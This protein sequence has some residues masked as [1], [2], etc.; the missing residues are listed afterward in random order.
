MSRRTPSRTHRLPRR[1][2]IRARAASV[3]VAAGALAAVLPAVASASSY[4]DAILADSPAV[5]YRMNGPLADQSGNG[6]TGNVVGARSSVSGAIVGDADTATT[7]ASNAAWIASY[8]PQNAFT[9]EGWVKVAPSVI[10]SGFGCF[11]SPWYLGESLLNAEVG[12]VTNDYGITLMNGHVGFG[13]GNGDHTFCSPGAINDG[14]YHHIVGTWD[15]SDGKRALYIDGAL[16]ASAGDGG[17]HRSP[18]SSGQIYGGSGYFNQANAP[19]AITFDEV[20]IYDKRLSA[21]QVASHYAAGTR[22]ATCKMTAIRRDD[23]SAGGKDT[24]DVTVSSGAGLASIGNVVVSN[25]SVSVPTIISGMTTPV[26]VTAT[27]AV[28]GTPTRFSFNILDVIGRSTFC[29]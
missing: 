15:S 9:L 14:A 29:A 2:S 24:A 6:R 17:D 10:G 8:S 25:G 18:R 22:P 1:A 21:S 23:P 28:Q 3:A 4:S 16:V 19:G 12:G 11:A 27:K 7:F 20:A 26:V 13:V 5:Y